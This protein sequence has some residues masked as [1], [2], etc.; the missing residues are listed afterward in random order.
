YLLAEINQIE[1]I[2]ILARAI[3]EINEYKMHLYYK[4][5]LSIQ[6]MIDYLN[7]IDALL[8]IR[9]AEFYEINPT[10]I[11][12]INETCKFNKLQYEI[13]LYQKN[14]SIESQLKQVIEI[15]HM[16]EE[17][18]YQTILQASQKSETK[19]EDLMSSLTYICHSSTE[20]CFKNLK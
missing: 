17:T 14:R 10:F 1:M 20:L 19:I 5:N 6:N 4:E 7:R 3:K 18:L 8:L 2:Q 12:L 11:D 15:K 16:N 9:V 13:K